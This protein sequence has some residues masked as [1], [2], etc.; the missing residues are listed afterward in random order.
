VLPV[1]FRD[2]L[3]R[4]SQ[5]RHTVVVIPARYQSTRLPGKPLADLGGEPMIVHVYRRARD[6]SGVDAVIVAT[7]DDRIVRAIEDAGG[8]ACLTSSDHRTGTERVAEVA[9]AI[10]CEI[11]I[12]LQGDEP[13][14]HPDMIRATIEPLARDRSLDMSTVCRAITNAD[15]HLDP[16]V[17]KVVRD[18]QGMALYFSRSPIPHLRGPRPTLWKHF[19]LY[20]YRKPFL[21]RL[22]QLA[23]TPLEQ[24]ESLEQ[25]RALE[26]GYRIYTA[27]TEHDSIGVDTPEDLDRARRLLAADARHAAVGEPAGRAHT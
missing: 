27:I 4:T 21:L 5:P 10:D 7:D 12:N 13:F 9:A 16:N 19:G 17:V 2:W 15:D 6:T 25:L 22:A 14:I 23:P 26:H 3:A 1:S 8:V 11:V 24:A 20:G 18:N